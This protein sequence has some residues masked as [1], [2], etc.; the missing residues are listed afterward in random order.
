MGA[1][2]HLLLL[3]AAVAV[4]V[5]GGKHGPQVVVVHD[6]LEEAHEL[7]L[8]DESIAAGV[9]RF[10]GSEDGGLAVQVRVQQSDG[11]VEFRQRQLAGSVLI[12]SVEHLHGLLVIRDLDLVDGVR[13]GLCFGGWCFGRRLLLSLVCIIVIAIIL[14]NIVKL[15]HH[16]LI[17]V[18]FLVG[19]V[20]AQFRKEDHSLAVTIDRFEHDIRIHHAIILRNDLG[21][22]G[23]DGGKFLFRNATIAIRVDSRKDR[24][25]VVVV[26]DEL[27]EG[28]KFVARDEAVT[29]FVRVLVGSHDGRLVVEIW[30]YFDDGLVKFR[31]AQFSGSVAIHLVKERHR[32]FW[33]GQ[34][35]ELRSRLLLCVL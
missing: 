21:K 32:I 6:V 14:Q 17:H 12:E 2:L 10:V 30:I 15:V 4:L 31:Q 27:Q 3:D 19:Q 7:V 13:L 16:I 1:L 8:H 26:H 33:Q 35:A 20:V 28:W 9:A 24:P 29:G 11:L 23:C 34:S 5:D 22:L 18:P 25:E